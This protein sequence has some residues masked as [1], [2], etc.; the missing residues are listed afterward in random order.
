MPHSRL[1]AFA[2][3]TSLRFLS[4]GLC[5][6]PPGK[7]ENTSVHGRRFLSGKWKL[8]CSKASAM[9]ELKFHPHSVAC[10]NFSTYEFIVGN[11]YGLQSNGA[12]LFAVAEHGAP[13]CLGH[14]SR[15]WNVHSSTCSLSPSAE[16]QCLKIACQLV[17]ACSSQQGLPKV[18]HTLLVPYTA[19]S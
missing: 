8:H 16:W 5:R 14:A 18:Q 1:V 10:S 19:Q 4:K 15:Q 12:A 6:L 11:C 7:P 2:D 9:E 3:M 17:Q 13:A